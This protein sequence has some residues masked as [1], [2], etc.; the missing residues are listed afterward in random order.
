MQQYLSSV[1]LLMFLLMR[2]CNVHTNCKNFAELHEALSFF[3]CLFY[4]LFFFPKN[5]FK[6]HFVQIQLLTVVIQV[7]LIQ[8]L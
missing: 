3:F 1:G 2:E 7:L 8:F 4:L 5:S 6:P